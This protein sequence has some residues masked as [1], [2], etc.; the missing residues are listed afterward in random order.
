MCNSFSWIGNPFSQSSNSFSQIRNYT[1]HFLRLQ[2]KR[3]ICVK[4]RE[5]TAIQENKLRTPRE[6]IIITN[7]EEGIPNPKERIAQ[8]EITV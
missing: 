5:Q 7:P 4:S 2:Y 3:A 6:P 8:F 1:T